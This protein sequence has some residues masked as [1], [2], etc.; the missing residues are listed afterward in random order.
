MDDESRGKVDLAAILYIVGGIPA[1]V[2]V[3]VILFS[4]Q[5]SQIPQESNKSLP[6]MLSFR[7]GPRLRLT[8][9]MSMSPSVSGLPTEHRCPSSSLKIE[10]RC[11]SAAIWNGRGPPNRPCGRRKN[12]I[13]GRP[14]KRS[15]ASPNRLAD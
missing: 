14:S 7:N 13:A 2:A 11:L 9:G 4:F 5:D 10:W 6:P 15:P 12:A 8:S 1:I 3:L